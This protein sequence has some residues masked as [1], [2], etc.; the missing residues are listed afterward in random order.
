M[1]TTSADDPIGGVAILGRVLGPENRMLTPDA[2]RSLLSLKFNTEDERRM[3]RL[4]AKAR[5]GT[6]TDRE[7]LQAEQF[8]LVSHL[9]AL[10]QAK[11]RHAL[12]EHGQDAATA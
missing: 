7:R 8:N 6:L 4:A 9:L 12:R 10:L 1:S 11:A 3:N 5:K 2:A